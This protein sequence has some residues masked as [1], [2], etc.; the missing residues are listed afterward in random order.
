MFT[1]IQLSYVVAL[2]KY[3]HFGRA[4]EACHVTQP[5]LSM[6]IQKLEEELG[7]ILFDRSARPITPTEIGSLIVARARVVLAEA[8]RLLATAQEVTG[9]MKGELRI[10]ILSTLAPYLL[11]LVIEPFSRRYPGVSLVFEELL[12]DEIV[13]H[14]KRDLLDGGLVASEVPD[15]GIIE[16][17]LFTE[18]FVAYVSR[19]HE[20]Y[21]RPN[22]RAEDLH[23]D[24]V[25]LMREG[26]SFRDQ[27]LE[28][29]AGNGSAGAGEKAVQ[30]ESDNL[31][32]LQRL[33]DRGYGM[34]LLP[35]LAVQGQGSSAPDQVRAFAGV[36]PSRTVRLIFARVLVRRH[37]VKAFASEVLKAVAPVL[38]EEALLRQG[39]GE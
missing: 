17:L 30:F 5:T 26:H 32:T 4:A 37:L 20:L 38:P 12:A 11:P 22:I 23:L 7:V 34:T 28:I 15:T 21:A 36:A 6:Q 27:V 9:E 33:V 3:R 39:A 14:V 24:Q 16:D 2:D 1:L 10:G 18:P 29:L 8:E 31:E 25:W 19:N 13:D 35:W